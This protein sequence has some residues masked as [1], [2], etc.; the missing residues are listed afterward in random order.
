MTD[1]HILLLCE[2]DSA[3]QI[4]RRLLRDA[5]FAHVK[6][7]H[8]GI[9]SARLIAGLTESDFYPD[10]VICSQKLEDMDGEQF[11]AI[12]RQHPRLL[13]YPILLVLS[14][15]D[16]AA[17]LTTL[18][19]GASALLGRPYSADTL[20]TR[21]TELLKH[22]QGR[23]CLKLGEKQ[24]DTRAFDEALATYGIL[25]KPSREPEDFFRLGMKCLKESRWNQAIGA[26]QIALTQAHIKAEAEMG[27]AAAYRG[28]GDMERFRAWLARAAETYL[29]ARRWH[30]A[31]AA[32]GR[33]LKHDPNARNPF[34]VRAR[35]LVR[36]KNYEDAAITLA[37]S[38]EVLKNAKPTDKLAAL[39]MGAEDPDAMFKA[40]EAGLTRRGDSVG[41]ELSANIRQ[42]IDNLA[43]EKK[44]RERLMALERKWRLAQKIAA[45][46][47]AETG[48]DNDSSDASR[49]AE[50][51]RRAAA[52]GEEEDDG[53]ALT[54]SRRSE[55]GGNA[56]DGGPADFLAPLNPANTDFFE[57]KSRLNDIFSVMKLTWKL[58]GRDKKR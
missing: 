9:E 31:R 42:S 19:C 13:S 24:T 27:M 10:L 35:E 16:E 33:L 25:L 8:S 12:V 37:E 36:E 44:E 47:K 51:I 28:K 48:P 22:C 52:F 6:T 2:N 34:I 56:E 1:K 50:P 55:L 38:L 14:S 41:A 32:Y 39:C 3:S 5:G 20:K 58:A 17:Q 46:K 18:G 4:D 23:A 26:F 30:Q 40:L 29:K 53:G 21:V 11:C 57:K 45:Q 7:S 49:D 15:E 54:D 43:A